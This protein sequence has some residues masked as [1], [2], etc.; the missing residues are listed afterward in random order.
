MGSLCNENL[1]RVLYSG[2]GYKLI[3]KTAHGKRKMRFVYTQA[4]KIS[5]E[6][7]GAQPLGSGSSNRGEQHP[8]WHRVSKGKRRC[9]W[10]GY[11]KG[12][13]STLAHDFPQESLVCYTFVERMA[14]G[15]AAHPCICAAFPAFWWERLLH[16]RSSLS[17]R[18]RLE[19]GVKSSF[20]QPVSSGTKVYQKP[21]SCRSSHR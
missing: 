16:K 20:S 7:R 18:K 13:A 17:N 2:I 21:P 5:R 14:D 4:K 1:L 3:F 11:P 9:P 10:Q 6:S 8:C 15:N 19:E 12:T